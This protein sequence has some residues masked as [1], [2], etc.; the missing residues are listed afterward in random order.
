MSNEAS[1]EQK[2][3]TTTVSSVAVQAGDT[4]IVIAV[5]KCGKWVKLQLAESTPN[6]LEIGSNQDEAKK[7]LQDHEFLLAKLKALEDHVWDLLHEADKAAE[8][9]KENSQ[10]YDAMADTLGDAWDALIIML[11]K[12][13]ALLELTSVFFENALEFA[14]K[15]DQ[16]ED[17]VKNTQEFDNID[18]LRKL[19]LQQEHHTKELLEKSL[20][21]LNK[22]QE[23]T[24]FIEEFKCEGPNANPELMQGAHSSCLKIDNLL[25]MLQD[26]RRQLDRFLKHQRQGLEQVLQICLWHQQENQVISWYKKNIRDY[27]HKQNLG[28]SLLENEELLQELEEM[29]IKLKEWNS[30]VEQLEAEALNILL[31]EDYTEK[32]HLK[33]SNQKICLLREEARFHMEERK[34]L[35]QEANDFFHT[36]GKVLDD[37]EGIESYLKIFNSEGLRLP[38]LTMKYEELQEAIKG[39]T[40]TTLQ[41]GQTLVNKAD[42]HSSWVTGI[43]KTM[44]YVKK[45][46]DQLIRQGPDYKELTLKKQQ[47]IAS[48]EGH[49]NKVSQSIKKITPMLAVGMEIGSYLSESE[50]VL[51]KHLE[52][53]KQTKETSHELE[54]AE[55][56]IKDMEEFEPEQ[57]AAFSSRTDFLNEELKKIEEN[58][59][60]KLEVLET[61]VAFLKSAVEVNDDIQNL[62]EFYKSEPLQT[63]REV[64]NK[65]TME[66]A[67]TQ[68]QKAIKKVFSTQNM[69]CNFL[70]LVNMVNESLILKIEKSVQVTEDIIADLSK[71]KKELTNLWAIWNFKITQV[72][73]IKQQC[74]IFK[75]QLKITT[76]GLEILQEALQLAATV[77]LG[78]DLFTVLELQKRL[79]EM[80]PQYQQLNA[81]LEYLI[82]LLELPRQKG[83]PVKENSERIS[84]LIDFHQ[85]VKNTMTEYDEIFNKTVKFH[86]IKK[87]LECLSK[88]GE[89]DI[90]EICE[91]PENVHHAK[92]YLVNAQEKHARI[93]QLYKLLIT[94]GV[95]ILSAV[96][97][98]NCV[99]VSVKNLKQQLARFE[100]E[101]INWSSKAAKYEEE[102]LQH[103]QHCTT[104]E[105]VN[106]L[107]E[108]FKDLKKKFN[109]L[110]FNYMKKTEKTRNLKVLK[111]QIQQVDTY[112]EKIQVL[113]KKLDNLEK[114]VICSEGNEPNAK[115]EVLL[116]SISDLQKQLNDFSRVVEDYKQNL[117]LMEHLQQMMEECQFWFE[118]V[119]AT[120]IRV[121]K[122]SAECR[123]REAIDSLYKQF[124]K[125]IEPTVP[126]QEEKIQQIIDL[127]KQL[128]GIE[129]GKKYVEKAVLKYKEIISSIDRLCRSL[130][131]FKEIK[132]DEFS[133]E[134]VTVQKEEGNGQKDKAEEEKQ[135]VASAKLLTNSGGITEKINNTLSPAS[136]KQ[137]RNKLAD[138]PIICPAGEDLVSQDTDLSSSAKEDSLQ[139]EF[140]AEEILSGDEYECISP[141]DI[142]LPPLSETPESNLMHSE[143]ELEEQCCCSSHSLHVGSYS[144]QMQ[145]TT[146]IKKVMEVSDLL[147]NSTC[148]GATNNR[149]ESS[150]DHT[151]KFCISS[152][153][154]GP[155]VRAVSSLACSLQGISETSTASCTI[156]AKPVYSMMSEVCKTHL[157]HLEL[158]K[159]MAETQ[160]QLH[161]LNNCTKTQDRLHALPDAF[162]GF[163]FQSDATRSCQ[164]QMVTREEIK[165]SSEKNSMAS[166]TGQ[167]PNFSQF[168]S[169]KTVM[170]GSPVTLE[171]EV[172]GFP[173]PTL[174]WYKKGQKLTADEHLKFL[175]KETKHTLFI[176]KVCDKDAGL[177]VVRAKNLNGTISSSAILDV[178]VQGKHPHFIQ[179][180]GHT[181]LQ[182]GE[183][184]ILHCTIHGNP[185]PHVCWTKDDNQVVS[186]D[187]SIEKLGDTYYLL[188]RNVVLADTGKYICVASNEI[189]KARCSAFVTVIEKNKTPEISAVTQAKSEWE[190]GYFSEEVTVTTTEL[191]QA[192][193]IHCVQDQRPVAK[194]LPVRFKEKLWLQGVYLELERLQE[195]NFNVVR[196][197][198]LPPAAEDRK[199]D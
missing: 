136:T 31:S 93:R 135:Q 87:E 186:G 182:E 23:L 66:S 108:S 71:E 129:E 118:D 146:S 171:V 3:S 111:I 51:N 5:L 100:C 8:E 47:W 122:Y 150:S 170:E 59:S 9:N 2:L 26:R 96:Q 42:S 184:L 154:S 189:G 153:D 94:H 173:E 180:F 166:L 30:T 69:G 195:I 77:D 121:D 174:T 116:G 130:R 102:L 7:L 65:I 6:L 18:S 125:F 137:E 148:A 1:S 10:V 52:L 17:F 49:L 134:L 99:N 165:S 160:E 50:R 25:E 101:S 197:P 149:M 161:D 112:A 127:A 72:K 37:L 143:T 151:E 89:L 98:P 176:Q 163:V 28:S 67:N 152:T 61:Y 185:K 113:K 168:L 79:N 19:L 106:E 95:D 54:A 45:K 104:Q 188:K 29:E 21:L 158:H 120:V 43:Q 196:A 157:Q 117:D 70:N 142:S 33:L 119:S 46:V 97:Q 178:K 80:K 32:E 190:D 107:R 73:P 144:L 35:L 141:D 177:Y 138:I 103:F 62:K 145:K 124:K 39:C 191:V 4:S 44:E 14:V 132:K 75:E 63:N 60:S 105:E 133:E 88:S 181:T 48:L 140:L 76:H 187:I 55:R 16:V 40:A 115:V 169:N 156:N 38:V 179:K 114:K 58:I 74:R 34:A 81:E 41:K 91:D 198:V 92:A 53:A 78:S 57:A 90:P 167:A 183:D 22:S 172:M 139:T 131:E 24:E 83:F 159:S 36:A 175:Q 192:H 155:K 123:T 12:R 64:E 162:S 164:K 82:K 193:D 126:Q 27:F 194:H 128:Y 56:I 13:Q 110:K 15:I 147:T 85:A 199:M 11:E 68:W 86:H 84:E 20:A 109:N